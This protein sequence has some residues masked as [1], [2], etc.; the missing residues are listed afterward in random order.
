MA[1]LTGDA[2]LNYAFETAGKS[3]DMIES[4]KLLKPDDN[5]EQTVIH[6]KLLEA[7]CNEIMTRRNVERA[8]RI[9]MSK[10]GIY[11][12]IGGQVADVELTGTVLSQEQLTYI[13][14]NKIVVAYLKRR[15]FV[16][17]Y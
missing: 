13:Y 7:Y 9:L 8:M 4:C 1:I 3:F 14:E 6:A 15:G 5:V 16:L 11:G 2:L 12:M 10:P 17:P